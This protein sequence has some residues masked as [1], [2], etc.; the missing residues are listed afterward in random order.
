MKYVKMTAKVE[1]IQKGD[2]FVW[3][4]GYSGNLNTRGQKVEYEVIDSE[5]SVKAWPVGKGF[6]DITV[7][8]LT[9]KNRKTGRKDIRELW[10]GTEETFYRPQQ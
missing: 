4:K 6:Q 10:L 8:T 3:V 5:T 1:D 2:V 9:I 7:V